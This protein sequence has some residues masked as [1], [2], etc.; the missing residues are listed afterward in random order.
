MQDILLLHIHTVARHEAA[1]TGLLDNKSRLRAG[2]YRHQPDKWRALAGAL[3]TRYIGQGRTAAYTPAGKPVI[4]DGPFFSL[5]H[6]GEYAVAAVSTS[7]PV[8]I[9]IENT[10]NT[11]RDF[12]LLAGRAF[13]PDELARY[14]AAKTPACFYE[15]W[16]QKEAAFKMTGS[17]LT[18]YNTLDREE[19]GPVFSR[20]FYER[21]PYVIALCAGEPVAVHSWQALTAVDLGALPG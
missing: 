16:T 8:G 17:A 12:D 18:A 7:A 14:H 21:V 5:A 3:L 4:P 11:R 2:A 20:V 6:S 15:I 10:E 9:D 19:S 1:L 13:F